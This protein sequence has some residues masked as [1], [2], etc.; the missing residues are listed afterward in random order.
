[1][2]NSI[3]ISIVLLFSILAFI[4]RAKEYLRSLNVAYVQISNPLVLYVF[5]PYCAM[6]FDTS[7]C[8]TFETH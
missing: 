3:C 1:M 6:H 7:Q 5:E 2:M 8:N 4:D